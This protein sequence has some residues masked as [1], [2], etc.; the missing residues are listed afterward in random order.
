MEFTYEAI[1]KRIDHSLLGPTLTEVEL[2]EGCRVAARY[3]VASVCIKPFAVAQASEILR[4]SGV[5]VGTTIGFPHGG[6]ATSV[7]VFE[8]ERAIAD[9]ATELDMVINIGHAIEGRWDQV[10]AEI[11]AITTTAHNGGAILKVIFENCYLTDEQ[12]I[13]LCQICGE[14]GADYVKTS[15]GYGTGGASH[16][17]LILMRK[18]APS[19][20]KLKAAGG[21]RDLDAAIAVAKLGCD[22]IG[23]SKTAEIL[24]ELTLRLAR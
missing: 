15:T 2:E 24:D 7:K 14:V 12:K 5:L 1:A 22:R 9:G 10:R 19:H 21:I 13:R 18:A 11:E 6:H 3:Q 20:V 4:G 8:S 17:D 23:A 16:A